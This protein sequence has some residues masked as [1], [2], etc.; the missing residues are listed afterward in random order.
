MKEAEKAWLI[1][2]RKLEGEN[3]Q[4]RRLEEGIYW[5]KMSYWVELGEIVWGISAGMRWD[6]GAAA[7]LWTKENFK[8]FYYALAMKSYISGCSWEFSKDLKSLS[9]FQCFLDIGCCFVCFYLNMALWVW[10]KGRLALYRLL[11]ISLPELQ[12]LH[13][14]YWTSYMTVLEVH[15]FPLYRCIIIYSKITYLWTLRLFTVF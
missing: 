15:T 9:A 11:L 5:R 7:L 4:S 10:P 8:I 13:N 12:Q 14:F 1:Y 2:T 6:S 3:N